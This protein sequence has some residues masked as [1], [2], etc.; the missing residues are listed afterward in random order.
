MTFSTVEKIL[1]LALI[2]ALAGCA[3][4]PATVAGPTATA[5]P[6]EP[7][8]AQ[9][10][11]TRAAIGTRAALSLTP[12]ASHT[13]PP[14]LPAATDT[15]AALAAAA[16]QPPTP[17]GPQPVHGIIL[18]IGDGLG[19]SHRLAAQWLAQGANTPLLMDSL[20]VRGYA[21]TAAADREITDS[22]AAATALASGVQTRYAAV[23]V[24]ADLVPVETILAQAQ[25][26]GWSVG[27]VTDVRLADATP[28]A[29]AAHV[30]DRAMISEIA[31]QMMTKEIH[32]LLGGGEENFARAGE[33]TCTGQPGLRGDTSL[34]EN[35]LRVGYTHICT[36]AQLAALDLAAT[37]KLLG[38]FAPGDLPAEGAPSLAELTA[39]AI[40]ILS[41]NPNGFFL[42]VEGGQIDT[43]AHANDS[44]G[45]VQATLALNAAVAQAQVYALGAPNTLIIVAADH[46]TG[47]LQLNLDGNQTGL[48]QE[49]PFSMPDGVPFYMDWQ[50][51]SHTATPV[52]VTS[53]GPYSEWLAGLYP[54]T[55][56]YDVMRAAMLGE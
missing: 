38:L 14:G 42:M 30:P 22:G 8:I 37:D 20:P 18:F 36:P 5:G 13:P 55:H 10:T 9:A 48:H 12:P 11:A 24:D 1:R 47:G 50:T 44:L 56:I 6:L 51:G 39:A 28:G 41:R 53:G 23:G 25:A 29:F 33:P 4:P 40:A 26:L 43:F 7:L 21:S 46:E 34:I 49:G 19:E 32:V 31:R 27:L 45:T 2:L 15:P 3:A 17:E 52:L 54:L 35:A 16:S